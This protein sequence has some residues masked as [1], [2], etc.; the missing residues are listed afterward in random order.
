M[1]AKNR[2]DIPPSGRVNVPWLVVAALRLAACLPAWPSR[3]APAGH[4][5]PSCVWLL[6]QALDRAERLARLTQ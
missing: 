1:V 5:H 3:L 4:I 2:I 6:Q